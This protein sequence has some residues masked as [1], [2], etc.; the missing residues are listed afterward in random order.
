MPAALFSTCRFRIPD[1]RKTATRRGETGAGSPVF[2]FLTDAKADL[3]LS[4][5]QHLMEVC[6]ARA[7]DRRNLPVREPVA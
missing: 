3:D 7:A 5:Y 2:G 4:E 1:G 6:R